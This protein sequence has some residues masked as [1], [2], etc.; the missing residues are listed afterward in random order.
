MWK[1]CRRPFLKTDEFKPWLIQ[2]GLF[3]IP[4]HF[5]ETAF[6]EVVDTVEVDGERLIVARGQPERSPVF[7]GSNVKRMWGHAFKASPRSQGLLSTNGEICVFS[8]LPKVLESVWACPKH[9]DRLGVFVVAVFE[10]VA[11]AHFKDDAWSSYCRFTGKRFAKQGEALKIIDEAWINPT[12][13]K[14]VGIFTSSHEF[15]WLF[16]EAM[17]TPAKQASFEELKAMLA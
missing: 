9:A 8:N 16:Q 2:Q 15:A 11:S 13:S 10:G 3:V 17:Q 5:V 6:V 1:K 7:L 4:Q 14:L 12:T